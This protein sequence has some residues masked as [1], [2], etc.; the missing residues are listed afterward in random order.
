MQ[1]RA[2]L[3]RMQAV[4][5]AV[6][7]TEAHQQAS[8]GIRESG[9]RFRAFR[10]FPDVHLQASP[11]LVVWLLKVIDAYNIGN[12]VMLKRRTVKLGLTS[13]F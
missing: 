11:V 4:R 8:K 9:L 2:N 13:R 10:W 7:P 12:A 3:F 5:Q 1:K 6:E